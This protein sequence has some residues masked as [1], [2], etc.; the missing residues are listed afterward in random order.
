MC[1]TQERARTHTHVH[2]QPFKQLNVITDLCTFLLCAVFVNA[3]SLPQP[4]RKALQ[5]KNNNGKKS[6]RCVYVHTYKHTV[7]VRIQPYVCGI[8]SQTAGVCL[9][10][11]PAVSGG[12][13]SAC[14]LF[15]NLEW[16]QLVY[17]P[18]GTACVA[19]ELWPLSVI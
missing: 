4:H 14:C 9:Q 18:Q 8:K 6:S 11:L 7:C 13:N 10:Y 3:F 16:G 12:F 1:N 17:S 5:D 2:T 15:Q 19:R